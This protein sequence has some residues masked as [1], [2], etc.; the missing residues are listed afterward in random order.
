[1][2]S[3]INK[4][5]KNPD[6]SGLASE[7]EKDQLA[8]FKDVSKQINELSKRSSLIE[9]SYRDRLR[10][11]EGVLKWTLSDR[12][13]ERKKKVSQNLALLEDKIRQT[14]KQFK[15]AQ[16]AY[17]VAPKTFNGFKQKIQIL[18]QT[19]QQQLAKLDKVYY[20]QREKVGSIVK[21]DIKKRQQRVMDYQLQARLAA[22]RLFDETSNKQRIVTGEVR[23]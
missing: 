14:K 10:R 16:Y 15:A 17:Q 3:R 2:L 8:S 21:V 20:K 7:P 11:V 13:N 9:A 6:G 4:A 19:Y 22:A 5:Y 12:Y 1:M 23:Q 18:D